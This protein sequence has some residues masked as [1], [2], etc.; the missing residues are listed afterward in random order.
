MPDDPV[1][2]FHYT[3]RR[4]ISILNLYGSG[5]TS[6]IERREEGLRLAIVCLD[7]AR[8]LRPIFQCASSTV[9]MSATLSPVGVIQ[10]MNPRMTLLLRRRTSAARFCIL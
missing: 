4:F 3:F 9:L 7:P 8:A 10:R 5:F 2:D 6:V 1:V